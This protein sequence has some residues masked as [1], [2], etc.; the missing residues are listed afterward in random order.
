MCSRCWQRHPD[1]PFRQVDNLI[2]R[3]DD[4]PPWLRDFVTYA[5]ARHCVGRTSLMVGR[6][7]RLLA[8]DPGRSPQTLL[9]RARRPGRSM[10][11]LAR[12]LEA[13]FV[14]NGLA[15]PL[16]QQ[17]RLATGRRQR[18]VEATP[19]PLRRVVG[20]FADAQVRGQ[21]RARRAGTR[22]RSDRTIEANL[23]TLRDLGRFL[24]NE[25]AKTDWAAVEANDVEAFL[26]LLPASRPRRLNALRPFFG[27]ARSKRIVL[28][29][30]TRNVPSSRTRGF[31]GEVVSVA[32]QRRLFRRWTGDPAVHPNEALVGM[33]ALLHGASSE[34]LRNLKVADVDTER[35]M[36]GLGRRPRPV[37]LDPATWATLERC[38]D[39]RRRLGTLNPH[40]IVTRITKTGS[41]PASEPYVT[42][43]LDAAGIRGRTLRST[44]LAELVVT[45]DPKLV[46]EA[47]GLK[48]E[49]VVLYLADH[50]QDARL[51]NL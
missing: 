19:E 50:V 22:P 37:P 12:T 33:L 44:R 36:M 26:A 11:A 15:F 38:L 46:A 17:A 27:W 31:H 49:G 35:R 8:D 28:I 51:A 13:F 18:R 23:G 25:R 10:G 3:L 16:D 29:D 24:V 14:A 42:H 5:A 32:E 7:G 21:E 41:S 4:P 9:E 34:E 45:L 40:V 43:V 6:L 47:F 30:P 1:R 2:A 39:H 48:P 20:L